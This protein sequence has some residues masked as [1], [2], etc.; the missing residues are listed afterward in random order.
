MR[1]CARRIFRIPL[2]SS[3]TLNKHNNMLDTSIFVYL[4]YLSIVLGT[5]AFRGVHRAGKLTQVRF[6]SDLTDEDIIVPNE[7][8]I[9]TYAGKGC[10][11]LAQPGEHNHFLHKQCVLIFDVN[12]KGTQGVILGKQ[13]AF[14]LGESSPG[15]APPLAPNNIFIG[16][17]AGVDMAIMFHKYDLGGASKYIGTCMSELKGLYLYNTS[18][19]ISIE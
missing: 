5:H 9:C 2:G 10:V 11:L 16:G 14:S 7:V 17:E 3:V 8:E 18:I 6:C 1:T 12:E 19:I 15:I 13:S 4:L